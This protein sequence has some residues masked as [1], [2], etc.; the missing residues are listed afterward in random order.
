MTASTDADTA[1]SVALQCIRPL[2]SPTCTPFFSCNILR[3]CY[4]VILGDLLLHLAHL[5]SRMVVDDLADAVLALALDLLPEIRV[6]GEVEAAD[7]QD[8]EL[9]GE[10]E[11]DRAGAGDPPAELGAK[12]VEEAAADEVDGLLHGVG[13]RDERVPDEPGDDR[14]RET[15]A[16]DPDLVVELDNTMVAMLARGA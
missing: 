9:D 1:I 15:E 10:D 12:R 8:A 14:E 2:S 4:A 7:G 5:S 6:G 16:R 13:R 11:E 3:C